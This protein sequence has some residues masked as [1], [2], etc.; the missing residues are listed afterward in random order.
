MLSLFLRGALIPLRLSVL[1]DGHH[2]RWYFC[3]SVWDMLCENS[4]S[5][6]VV[7]YD[8]VANVNMAYMY[9][10]FF[11]YLLTINESELLSTECK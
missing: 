1:G 4:A 3:P 11:K 10:G 6:Y 5:T 9:S 7:D 2:G 8:N